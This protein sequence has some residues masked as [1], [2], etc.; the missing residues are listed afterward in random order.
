MRMN[1]NTAAQLGRLSAQEKLAQAPPIPSHGNPAD[2]AAGKA[3]ATYASSLPAM[4]RN[5]F[6]G[7]DRFYKGDKNRGQL[8]GRGFREADFF[9]DRSIGSAS[10]QH[11]QWKQEN[12]KLKAAGQPELPLDTSNYF[13][14]YNYRT[15]EGKTYMDAWHDVYNPHLALKKA[16]KKRLGTG[17]PWAIEN[18]L[19]PGTNYA[20]QAKYN[21]GFE[22][23]LEEA[24]NQRKLHRESAREMFPE[25]WN[26]R[27][28][29]FGQ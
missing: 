24:Q 29:R 10:Y 28:W 18:P 26:L 9:R 23:A 12:A 20:S 8:L 6:S 1:N 22:T 19:M 5:Y 16:Y 7:N 17:S 21:A 25:Q 13:K 4:E 2:V 3:T 11:S 27:P 14:R 15:P